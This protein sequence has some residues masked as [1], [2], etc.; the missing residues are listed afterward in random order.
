[1][2]EEIW[3]EYEIPKTESK[4]PK[5]NKKII[6]KITYFYK[7]DKIEKESFEDYLRESRY[8]NNYYYDE[9]GNWISIKSEG[10][11]YQRVIRYYE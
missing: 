7:D 11:N 9:K 6:R 2:T 1:M 4:N 8:E 3:Y 10:Y 5:Q